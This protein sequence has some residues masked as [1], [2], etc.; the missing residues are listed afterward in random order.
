MTAA[1]LG[2]LVWNFRLPWQPRARVFLGNG[3]SMLLGF[4]IAWTCVRMSQNPA[5]PI[6][7]VL[8]PWTLALPLIDC[9]TLMFRRWRQGRSPFAADRGHMHHLLLDAGFSATGVVVLIGGLSLLLGAGAALA[10][11]LGV[12]RPLLVLL[13]LA[14]LVAW[15]AFT[16]DPARAVAHLRRLTGRATPENPGAAEGT[17]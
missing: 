11:K 1:L 8:G 6:S 4:V 7:P 10:V 16:H 5:H 17:P 3:G 9:V 2:F 13:F 14:L 12:Y 15:Y